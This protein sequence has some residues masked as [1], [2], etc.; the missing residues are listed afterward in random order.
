[1][2]MGA[3]DSSSDL[4]RELQS[5]RSTQLIGAAANVRRAMDRVSRFM[6]LVAGWAFVACAALIGVEVLVRNAF[7]W[8]TQ[9]TTELSGYLLA[10]GISWG[11]AHALATRNHVRID[12]VLNA[13]PLRARAL[14]HVVALTILFAFVCFV[15]Y[16]AV[17][18]ALESY[19]FGATDISLLR[20]PLVIPQGLW[21]GGICIFAALIGLMLVEALLLLAGG[22]VRKID[23]LYGP[24]TYEEEAQEA[25]DALASGGA[26]PKLKEDPAR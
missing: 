26:D 3:P 13:L 15:A 17:Q 24:R 18:L 20:T 10:F 5:R 6:G 9:S 12:V 14:L 19:D 21:A 1:M 8:S 23:S 25:L 16:G 11:L 2:A 4:W 7:G 22:D